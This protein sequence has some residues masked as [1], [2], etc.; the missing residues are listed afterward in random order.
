MAA[1]FDVPIAPHYNW[2]IHTQLVAT[3]PNGL[4]IEYFVRGSDVKVFDEVLA[5]PIYPDNTGLHPAAHR[6][7]F[8][9]D[10]PRRPHRALPHRMKRRAFL[11]TA[12]AL[13]GLAAQTAKGAALKI[14]CVGGHPDDPESGRG[15]TLARYA[16][17]G[18]R[19]AIIYLTRGEAGIR[20]KSHDEAAAIRTAECR[21]G[22][23]DP[24]R[25]ARVRRPDRWRHRAEQSPR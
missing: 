1:A 4:F 5:N 18:N 13:P 15:G 6:A 3:I 25:E 17:A 7:G 22:V 21:S 2:D 24:G 10:L 12:A 19:V 11:Q 20:D 23:Q 16:E 14:V 8:R 9:H